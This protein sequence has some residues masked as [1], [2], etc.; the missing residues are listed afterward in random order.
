MTHEIRNMETHLKN[1]WQF[2]AWGFN[3]GMGD[4]VTMTDIDGLYAYWYETGYAYLF[5][6]M[7]HWDGTGEIPH[8]NPRSGQAVALRHLS[9]ESSFTVLIGYGDTSTRTVHYAE[10]WNDGKVHIVNFRDA[11]IKWWAYQ[12]GKRR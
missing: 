10:V 6:E 9:T 2:D 12:N 1:V 8:I 7:K 11:L 3:A 5:I 4:L